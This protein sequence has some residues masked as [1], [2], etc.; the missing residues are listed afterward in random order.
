MSFTTP[1]R[2]SRRT[3][4]RDL[5]RGTKFLST[6]SRVPE[7]RAI[8]EEGAGYT[9]ADHDEGWNVLL[10][11]MGYNRKSAPTNAASPFPQQ[12]ALVE[13]DEWDGINFE[14]TRATLRYAFPAQ[15]DYLFQGL[16]AGTGADAIGSVQTYVERVAALRDGTDPDRADTRE[17]D[18]AAAERLEQRKIFNREIQL[19]LEG[20]LEQAKQLAPAPKRV[21]NEA[22]IQQASDQLHVWLSDW[23]GQARAFI[24][25]GDYLIR[26]G[27]STRKSRSGADDEEEEF[28]DEGTPSA[29]DSNGSV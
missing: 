3:A 8:L 24:T 5:V 9:E 14:R 17:A 18:Q 12:A 23:T 6:L 1:P 20:L 25:R 21:E 28:E 26:L 16:S 2:V 13:L 19:H 27:L 7:I 11:A 22:Q 29:D 4:Q 15:H 10:T